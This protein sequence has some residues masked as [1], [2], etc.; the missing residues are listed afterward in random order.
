MFNKNELIQQKLEGGLR[1]IFHFLYRTS[2][3]VDAVDI[4]CP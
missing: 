1:N 3:S 2:I 4:E